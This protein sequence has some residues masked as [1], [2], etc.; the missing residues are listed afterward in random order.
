M[1]GLNLLGVMLPYMPFHYLLFRKLKT[2]AI[3]LTS[4][5]FSNEPILIDNVEATEKFSL[6]LLM[7]L[8]FTTVKYLTVQMIQ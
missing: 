1:P 5:N 2:D 8:F 4:G 6:K 3:V 7:Q